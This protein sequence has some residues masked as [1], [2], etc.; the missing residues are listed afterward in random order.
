M[1][2]SRAK[3]IERFQRAMRPT[4]PKLVSVSFSV[5]SNRNWFRW[6]PYL[7]HIPNLFVLY[8]SP[9]LIGATKF[10]EVAAQSAKKKEIDT[11]AA[12]AKTASASLRGRKA[13]GSHPY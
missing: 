4:L 3:S 12:T 2:P 10:V 6:T 7:L 5:V 1:V 9:T 8:C 11:P 13:T